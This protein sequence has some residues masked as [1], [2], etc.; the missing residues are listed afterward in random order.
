MSALS[1]NLLKLR[2]N[3]RPVAGE[4]TSKGVSVCLVGECV[5]ENVDARVNPRYGDQCHVDYAW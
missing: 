2:I 3:S 4:N 5:E 1:Q